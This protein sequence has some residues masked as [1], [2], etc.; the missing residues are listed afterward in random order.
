VCGGFDMEGGGEV[1]GELLV[2]GPLGLEHV[3]ELV[4]VI[5]VLELLTVLILEIGE[6]EIPEE[7]LDKIE[8]L[9]ELEF[10]LGVFVKSF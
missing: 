1:Y 9:F 7:D 5:L 6:R 2:I 10:T 3:L 4:L 8:L